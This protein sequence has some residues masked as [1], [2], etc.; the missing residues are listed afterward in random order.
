MRGLMATRA[1]AACLALLGAATAL[2]TEPSELASKL[3]GTWSNN[4]QVWQHRNDAE[5]N[6]AS[7]P[8]P[9][10]VQQRFSSVDVPEAGAGV[11]VWQQTVGTTVR[12]RL[13][14]LRAGDADMALNIETY[15]LPDEA[16]WRDAPGSAEGT[17]ALRTLWPQATLEC[18]RNGPAAVDV[19]AGCDGVPL[20]FRANEL[21]SLPPAASTVA[22]RSRAVRYFEGWLWIKHAGPQAAADDRK[23]SF[24]RRVLLHNEGQ[25]AVVRYEDGSESP[26]L[27]ELAQLTYQ[28][29]RKPILKLALIDRATNK[30]LSYIWANTEATMIGM[31]L[32]WFQAGFTQKAQ[33][34]GFAD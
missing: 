30:S 3:S 21:E 14:R 28:N 7:G 6:K 19:P 18:R 15:R 4:E 9:L 12:H 24:T 22:T 5:A 13:L 26:Y 33:R 10:P 27:L 34:P 8:A 16:R 20:A 11:L 31:N 29:T 17:A 23:A 2:A 1:V 32:G 25:R